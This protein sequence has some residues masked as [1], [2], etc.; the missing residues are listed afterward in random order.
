M[1]RRFMIPMLRLLF[2]GLV[3]QQSQGG[4]QDLVNRAMKTIGG[5]PDLTN[6]EMSRVSSRP[7]NRYRQGA[8]RA[9]FDAGRRGKKIPGIP[10]RGLPICSR[11]SSAVN[12]YGLHG[13]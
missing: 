8:G 6:D 9:L 4:F 5:E 13:S 3:G 11:K 12:N 1:T 2:L 7:S 10:P